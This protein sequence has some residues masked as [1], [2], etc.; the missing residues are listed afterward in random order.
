MAVGGATGF[1]LD[2]L[3]PGTEDERG[4]I[5]FQNNMLADGSVRQVTSIHVYDPPFLTK[6]FMRSNICKYVPFLLYYEE[7]PTTVRN[8]WFSSTADM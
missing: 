3:L 1:I 8:K 5:T 4:I 7:E 2:N 6:K